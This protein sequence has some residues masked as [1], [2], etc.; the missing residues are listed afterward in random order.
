MGLAHQSLVSPCPSFFPFL[1]FSL[2]SS[3]RMTPWG[4]RGSLASL[5]LPGLLR[6]DWEGALHLHRGG[7]VLRPHPT[8]RAP[9]ASVNRASSVSGA[10]LAFCVNQGRSSLFLSPF[11]FPICRRCPPEGI[12]GSYWGWTLVMS[13]YKKACNLFFRSSELGVPTPLGM[14]V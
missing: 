10:L 7:G 12:P 9:A 13:M 4:H 6:P 5:F 3:F 14:P 1:S 2:C 11:T 8:E